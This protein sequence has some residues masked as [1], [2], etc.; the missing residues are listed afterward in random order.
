MNA[1]SYRWSLERLLRRRAKTLAAYRKDREKAEKKKDQEEI[2][3]IDAFAMHEVDTIDDEIEA[4]ESR[5]LTESAGRLLLPTPEFDPG[6]SAW[7]ESSV[8]GRF[9]LSR[10]VMMQ[11]RSAIRKER[12][13]RR[14][15]VIL[16]ITALTG[17]I[18]ALTGLVAV[19]ST[20]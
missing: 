11:L 2:A 13:E 14:E 8:T 18:G 1:L 16:W 4:L 3:G 15:G 10:A 12:K 5:Y 7:V 9:R 17:I 19:W 20:A 6:S